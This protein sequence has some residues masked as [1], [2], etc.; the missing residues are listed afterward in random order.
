MLSLGRRNFSTLKLVV[1]RHGQ[2]ED[3][4]AKRWSGWT[5]AKLTSTGRTDAAECAHLI[6][7]ENLEFDIA[8]CSYLSRSIDTL[9]IILEGLQSRNVEVRSRWQLN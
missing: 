9:N 1:L 2:T 3:N 8:Y 5:D 7:K 4:L 6:S